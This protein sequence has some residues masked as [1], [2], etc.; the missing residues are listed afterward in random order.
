VPRIDDAAR[1]RRRQ[2]FIEAARRCV[3]A[4]GYRNLSI[5][6]VCAEA[7]LS[8]GAFYTYFEQKQDLLIA[9]LD[10]DAASL[11]HLVDQASLE[12]SA[13]DQVRAFLGDIVVRGDDPGLVQLRADLWAE[14]ASDGDLRARF[15]DGVRQRRR[16]LT[17]QLAAAMEGG[18]IVDV[19]ANALASV[20]LALAEGLM[21]HRA[22][23]PSA[24]RWSNVSK[25]LD[26][27]LD[28]LQ[29]RR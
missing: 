20:V 10:G 23:D 19:P 7:G 24:F 11:E 28:G 22:L 6:D 18:D 29:Q 26:A 3:A 14:L 13:I 17:A 8:K 2:E 5:D 21:L 1:N 9:L 4:G 15:L 16:R 12:T 25:V 27:L